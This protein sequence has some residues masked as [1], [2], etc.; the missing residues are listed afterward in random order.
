M[1]P[2]R[3]LNRVDFDSV[4]YDFK[5]KP[6]NHQIESIKFGC[7]KSKWILGDE[8]G[9]GKTK[10]LIDI[11]CIHK[12]YNKIQHCLIIC[13]VNSI[14]YNWKAEIGIHSNESAIVIDG[15][16]KKRLELLR[17]KPSEFFYI[18]N[19]ES[20]RSKEVLAELKDMVEAGFI[21]MIVIDEAHKCK[22]HTSIQ[23]KA[24]HQLNS[25]IKIAAT[26]TP[27]M[28][29]PLDAYNILKWLGKEKHSFYQFKNF[30]CIMGG[31]N[32]Y[33][34]VGYKNLDYLQDS[35]QGTMLR[36]LKKDVLDLPDKIRQEVHVDLSPS[37]KRLYKEIKDELIEELDDIVLN[38]NPLAK[39]TRLRQVTSCPATLDI[40]YGYGAKIER[41]LE[42]IQ[43]I[44]ENNKK[45]LVFSNWSS[46]TEKIWEVLDAE[47]LKFCYIDGSVK[48]RQAQVDLFQNNDDYKIC[49]GTIGAMGTGLT[50][51]A[52][53]Y[54]IFIDSPWNMANKEQAEDRA[55]R[56]GTTENVTIYTLVC[57]NTIDQ[58]I[59]QI[60]NSKEML[61][62]AL[63]DGNKQD[64]R[65]LVKNL[66]A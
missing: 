13:G 1:K 34:V 43:E 66:L 60:I 53:S 35:L 65:K 29:S 10:C 8:M 38:P 42:I 14:K 17:N 18:I 36:R 5:T 22:S 24:I 6:F 64:L 4:N 19:I 49:V 40:D 44:T 59:E 39:L 21:E 7:M 55:Y 48:D 63:V 58:K 15:T 25:P 32:N 50:L 51:T 23:G 26:G 16:L 33:Q 9:L 46:V 52:A 54:V 31:F 41:M 30:Y 47:N 3:Q 56:I 57:E 61:S 2:K 37:Q 20:L 12:K 45:V 62:S 11:A 28:N 27:I